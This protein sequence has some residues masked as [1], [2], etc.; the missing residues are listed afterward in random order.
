MKKLKLAIIGQGRSG[1]DIH[2][3]YYTSEANVYFDVA[4]VVDYDERCRKI[5]LEKY[6]GCQVLSDYRELF[7]KDVDL[8][9]NATTSEQHYCVTKDL[10]EHD[11]NVLVEKPFSKTRLEC[12][13]LIRTAKEHGVVLAVFQNTSKSPYYE[14]ILQILENKTLGEVQQVSLRFNGFSR[15]WDWQTSQRRL[16]GI[17]YNMGPHVVGIAMAVLGFSKDVKIVYSKLAT[18][19]TSG[20]AED[21]AK[22]LLEAPGKPLVDIELNS[23]DAYANYNVKMQGSRGTYKGT[24]SQYEMKYYLDEE[25]PQPKYIDE[26]MKSEEGKPLFCFETLKFH[27]EKGEYP[28]TAFDIG[29][30][31]IYRDV[32]YAI[33]EGKELPISCEMVQSIISVM[34]GVVASNPLEIKF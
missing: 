18:T 9:V 16:G 12:E 4:Y 31:G 2:G 34:E 19:H 10:L 14:H 21:Y 22:I 20:D 7:D 13:T 23:T 17:V 33:T 29:T 1:M 32:Y 8:V 28:G 26:S 11:K 15:R 27:E 30:N 6:K 5:A 25:N 3:A 24:T